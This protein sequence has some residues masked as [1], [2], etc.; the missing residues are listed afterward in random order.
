MS[1]AFSS[2][3]AYFMNPHVKSTSTYSS[4]KQA[5]TGCPDIITNLGMGMQS[6]TTMSIKVY[7]MAILDNYMFQHLL[8]I[9]RLS[10]RELNLRYLTTY[11]FQFSH[12]QRG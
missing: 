8:A 1:R 9:F 10:S 12:T 5:R 3:S 2:L 6:N 7:L 4:N 11:P